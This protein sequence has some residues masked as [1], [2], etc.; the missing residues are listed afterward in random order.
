MMK[1]IKRVFTRE[2]L[3]TTIYTTFII[4]SLMFLSLT[5]CTTS[6][7]LP[8]LCYNDRDGTYICPEEESERDMEELEPIYEYC[9]PWEFDGE[10]WMNC[11]MNEESRRN[12]IR[13]LA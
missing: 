6:V 2:Y 9:E 11:I 3:E 8:G 5:S 1:L 7:V 4:G 10:A 13:R 12:L